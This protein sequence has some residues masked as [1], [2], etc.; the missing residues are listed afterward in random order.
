MWTQYS[1]GFSRQDGVVLYDRFSY[2]KL[3]DTSVKNDWTVVSRTETRQTV[4]VVINSTYE[5]IFRFRCKQGCGEDPF[6]GINGAVDYPGTISV[7]DAVYARYRTPNWPI[8][9][10][11]TS[12]YTPNVT[13]M[14]S[15]GQVQGE[16]MSM[17]TGIKRRKERKRPLNLLILKDKCYTVF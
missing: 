6:F 9:R 12:R 3:I 16:T 17:E 14:S 10:L 7:G 1:I 5:I 2:M 8:G 11:Q 13:T 15:I 4:A